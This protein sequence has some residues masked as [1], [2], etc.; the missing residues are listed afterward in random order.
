MTSSTTSVLERPNAV[1][2][3]VAS[4]VK[5]IL[6]HIQNDH[7]LDQRLQT[8]LSLAR[9]CGAH[10]SCL[11]VTAIEA[12]AAFDSFGGVFAMNDVIE[13]L[14]KEEAE[15]RSSV[16]NKLR[17]EDVSWNYIQVTGNVAGQIVSHAALA[18]LV[19]VGREAHGADLTKADIGSLGD[20]IHRARTP[21]LIAAN[22]GQ[23][24]D[25]NGTAMIA[26]NGSY[27]VANAIRSSTGLLKLACTV[28][29]VQIVEEDKN[30]TFPSTRLLEYLSRHDIHAEL[31]TIDAG[32]ELQDA[33]VIADMLIGRARALDAAYLVMGG[34][35]HSRV[36][37]YIFG[38]V[39]RTLLTNRTGPLLIAH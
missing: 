26:W 17:N 37:E 13:A 35:S 7:S 9:A 16:E 33:Y 24:C 1:Q 11:H 12:Y 5:T 10:L 27:E 21:L 20:L 30:Q 39:T 6:V 31:S 34:Y 23:L 2:H 15:L 32:V 8:A 18:D 36:S 25:P 14:D 29:V 28:H 4:G 19:I 3:S 38:G 22:D